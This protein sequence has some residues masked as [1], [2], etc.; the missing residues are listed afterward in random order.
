MLSGDL[1]HAYGLPS[2]CGGR[3][4]YELQAF[5]A[6]VLKVGSGTLCRNPIGSS[7]LPSLNHL[8]RRLQERPRNRQAEGLG[9]LEVH[10][11]LERGRLLDRQVPRRGAI[12]DAIDLGG[13]NGDRLLLVGPARE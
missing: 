5:R 3:L 12:A 11:Q 4:D 7:L 10:D 9:G 2:R 13:Y 1:I 6:R 8:I